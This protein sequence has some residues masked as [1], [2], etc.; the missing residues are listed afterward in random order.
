MQG[1]TGADY[2]ESAPD[3]LAQRNGYRDRIW[4]TRAGTAACPQATNRQ[5]I[6]SPLSSD[7]GCPVEG[8]EGADAAGFVE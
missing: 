6:P 7:R 5:L 3:R 2:G 8:A 4:E 1:L